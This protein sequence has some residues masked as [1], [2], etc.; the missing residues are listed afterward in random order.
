MAALRMS[1]GGRDPVPQGTGGGRPTEDTLLAD[2]PTLSCEVDTLS[3]SSGSPEQSLHEEGR[4]LEANAPGT[5]KVGWQR[6]HRHLLGH[7]VCADHHTS[8]TCIWKCSTAG[9]GRRSE[10][11]YYHV[12]A[13]L[14]C[15]HANNQESADIDCMRTLGC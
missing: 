8:C 14:A 7:H 13:S 9:L 3:V 5:D 15:M 2:D 10:N 12:R 11:M 1:A 4:S 6:S